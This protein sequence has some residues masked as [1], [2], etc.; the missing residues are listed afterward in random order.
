[1]VNT[2]ITSQTSSK[3]FFDN[4]DK[5]CATSV[6]SSDPMKRL[7]EM[8]FANRVKNQRLLKENA[9]DLAKVIELLSLDNNDDVEWYAHRH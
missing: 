2:Y 7:I 4:I 5:I 1:L 6:S 8:G 3:S 9:N